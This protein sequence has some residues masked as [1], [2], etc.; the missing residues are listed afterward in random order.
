MEAQAYRVQLPA[1]EGPLDLLLHL[2][3]QQELDIT[4]IALAQVTDQYLA[5]LACRKASAERAPSKS[6]PD[7]LAAFLSVAAR[8]LL[9]KSRALLPR[10]PAAD[11]SIE[12]VGE[13]LVL[14]LR[15]YRRFKQI[16]LHLKQRDEAAQH[17]YPRALPPS[18][19]V[20][21]WQPRLD[22][23]D[24][25]LEDLT[26]ALLTLLQEQ[27]DADPELTVTIDSVTIDD[28][29][30]Q[31]SALLSAGSQL[32]FQSLLADVRSRLE[33]IVTLLALLEMIRDSRITVQQESLFGPILI[34][35]GPEP[36]SAAAQSA[37]EF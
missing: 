32:T 27:T 6:V 28:K 5:Y 36:A 29:I 23:S 13:D 3:E 14:Q 18:A 30:A 22:L 31:I 8:L 9:I 34:A 10:P 1:F 37:Q 4:T 17:M 16:A 15:A 19:Q 20:E 24:T 33:I 7:D 11:E 12:D 26:A 2:I 35:P 21:G 25:S